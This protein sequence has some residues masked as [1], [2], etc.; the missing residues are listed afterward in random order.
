MDFN[1]KIQQLAAL[2]HR[3]SMII[4]HRFLVVCTSSL[5]A[6]ELFLKHFVLRSSNKHLLDLSVAPLKPYD[7]R[8][9]SFVAPKL[10]NK[11]PLDIGLS[12]VT[13]LK[14]KLKDM[15]V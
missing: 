3:E 1:F 9:Y 15:S 5:Y 12:S 6:L 11:L 4:L 7:D 13:I 8:A 14:T 2:L 10:W